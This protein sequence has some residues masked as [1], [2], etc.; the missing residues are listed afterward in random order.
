MSPFSEVVF[1]W[2]PI[3]SPD[4]FLDRGLDS[5]HR[6]TTELCEMNSTPSPHVQQHPSTI[7]AYIR[8]GWSL[9]AIAPNSKAPVTPNW[10]VEENSL[11][12]FNE[13]QPGQGIGLAHAYSGTMALDIDEWD[14][15]S[16]VLSIMGVDLQALYDAPD[17]VVIHSGNPG[18]GKL[19]YAMPEGVTLRS[20]K[21][22]TVIEG[23]PKNYLDFRC[24]TADGMTVQD[25][26]PP[27]LHPETGQSYRWAGRGKWENLPTIPDALLAIWQNLVEQ[28]SVRCIPSND[29]IRTSWDE[30]RDALD[31]VDPS[32]TREQWVACGM[33][34]HFAGHQTNDVDGAFALWNE[35]SAKSDKKYPGPRDLYAQWRSFKPDKAT[36]VKIGTLFH[37][38]RESGWERASPD[39]SELFV[40]AD[41]PEKPDLI[42]NG[43]DPRPPNPS[44]ESWPDLLRRRAVEVA[45]GIGCD[46]LIPLLAGISAISGACDSRTRLELLPGFKVPPVVWCMII[47]A[48]GD[49]K[50]PGSRPMISPLERLEREALPQFATEHLKW[51]AHQ[52]AHAAAKKHYLDQAASAEAILTG[53]LPPVPTLPMEPQALRLK[54]SDIT[55]QKLVRVLAG[56]P[57]GL[58]V[59]LDEMAAW[60]KKLT[61]KNGGEDRSCWVSGYE[62]EY[63]SMDRVGAGTIIAENL[64][65]SFYGNVQPKILAEYTQRLATDGLLQR[66]IPAPVR[67]EKSHRGDPV[68]D[69]MTSA[70]EWE[71][72]LRSVFALP[73][74]T[75]KLSAEA[76][77]TFR[78][79]QLWYEEVK[80]DERLMDSGDIFQGAIAKLE[81][82]TGRLCLLLHLADDPY[83]PEVSNDTLM[84]TIDIIQEYV[85]PALRFAFTDMAEGRKF[86]K[87]M[88]NHI[89]HHCD[90][91]LISMPEIR[92]A[93]YRLLFTEDKKVSRWD[94][95]QKILTAAY[96][97]EKAKWIK[98]IDDGSREHQGFAQWGINPLIYIQFKEQRERVIIARQRFRD[99]CYAEG[100]DFQQF[101]GR[102]LVTHYD[103]AT[104]DDP[105]IPV[106]PTAEELKSIPYKYPNGYRA[107]NYDP[108]RKRT[109]KAVDRPWIGDAES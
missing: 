94:A 75:Y 12:S 108:D 78:Q 89:L 73:A 18:H 16:M 55:S 59:H 42:I 56:Q 13:L 24:A 87:W 60:A 74:M 69:C 33:A 86:E 39:V 53:D 62:S 49:K 38:A 10:Q 40:S 98:R 1:R 61:D 109:A 25:V 3:K 43:M 90:N 20:R 19:L 99:R 34:L 54:L 71:T 66:F 5:H 8:Y 104:M 47:G 15:A 37:H 7:D 57:R 29:A 107:G 106:P 11:K 79:F 51:E 22:S 91:T 32:C 35:W 44:L 84:R 77:T 93:A 65:I 50:S 105:N 100:K 81:G 80:R 2:C 76:Y 101:Q 96:Y 21:L 41:D 23:R 4:P 72:M 63:Y 36:A 102:T 58:L 28:D 64:S 9:V 85:I 46:P 68:P 30:I 67:E 88:Y 92:N 82:T 6:N 31:H 48:P 14:S 45:D 83:S 26:L 17:A 70:A 97:L 27:S 103:P 52:A 95:D